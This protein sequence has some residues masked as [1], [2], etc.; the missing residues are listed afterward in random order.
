MSAQ[1]AARLPTARGRVDPSA[2]VERLTAG[3]GRAGRL[4]HL[5]H[6]PARAAITADWPAW[7]DPTVVA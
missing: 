7:A 1:P 2:L 5:E 3:P 4:T 6:V